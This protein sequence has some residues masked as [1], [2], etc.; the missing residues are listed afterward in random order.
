[1]EYILGI[2]VSLL[3]QPIKKKFGGSYWTYLILAILALI[4]AVA[5]LFVVNTEFWPLIIK[6]LI[7]AGEIGRAHV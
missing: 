7:T 5:Y 4:G 6:T 2:L 3:V 1:M